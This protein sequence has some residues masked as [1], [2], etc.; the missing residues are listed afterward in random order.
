MNV[1]EGDGEVAS[2]VDNVAGGNAEAH[3]RAAREEP[4][5]TPPW[6]LADR[7]V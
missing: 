7:P 3:D 4:G 5:W 1:A 6:P 2:L